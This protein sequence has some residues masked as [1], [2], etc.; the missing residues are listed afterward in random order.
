MSQGEQVAVNTAEIKTL[1]TSIFDI[2]KSIKHIEKRLLGRPS[3]LICCLVGLLLK[4]I[5]A[6]TTYIVMIKMAK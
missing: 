2:E 5:G 1:K 3:W 4:T 6:L